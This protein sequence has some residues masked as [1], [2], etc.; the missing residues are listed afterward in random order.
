MS[1]SGSDRV[2]PAEFL[3]RMPEPLRLAFESRDQKSEA[4]E[5]Y[6]G[7]AQLTSRQ[8]FD[9]MNYGF[10]ALTP[11]G[12]RMTLDEQ[13]EPF[14]CH[15]QLYQEVCRPVELA[16]LRVL[17]V[18]SG[19]G[20]GV[21]VLHRYL[22]AARVTGVELSESAVRLSK[23]RFPHPALVF[24]EGDAE[25]LPCSDASFDAVVNVESSHCYPNLD[26]FLAEVERV[27]RPG[28]WFLY[29]DF[30]TPAA[31]ASVASHAQTMG[32]S[33]IEEEDITQNVRAS[34]E[35]DNSRKERLLRGIA[36]DDEHF[37]QLQNF[38]RQVGTHGFDW[39]RRRDNV[40]VRYAFSKAA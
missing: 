2:L 25:A 33:C 3:R 20:G 17:E 35:R 22:R 7:L 28:G 14:R 30:G 10:A 9:F 16:G 27:L 21:Y 11:D 24:V 13:D 23:E 37:R 38:A 32:L 34:L 4:R 36:R 15:I 18:G 29:A 1:N 12:E 8:R 40:Y 19:R 31:M 39:F 6:E 5:R 26:R